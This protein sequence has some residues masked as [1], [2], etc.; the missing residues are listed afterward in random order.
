MTTARKN[1]K[2][3]KRKK[4]NFPLGEVSL[5][6]MIAAMCHSP[7]VRAAGITLLRD[8][9]FESNDLFH[10]GGLRCGIEDGAPAG[11]SN[12]DESG[13]AIVF[14]VIAELADQ[15]AKHDAIPAI[16][17]KTRI[18]DVFK[19]IGSNGLEQHT[20]DEVFG[21]D[22]SRGG[23]LLEYIASTSRD[24]FD[25]AVGVQTFQQFH[26]QRVTEMLQG[27][28]A[29]PN[30]TMRPDMLES[31]QPYFDELARGKAYGQGGD[32]MQ[33]LAGVTAAEFSAAEYTT[34][35]LVNSVMTQGQ[36]TVIGGPMK[37]MKTSIMLDLA[38][39]LAASQD[40]QPS[41][42]LGK[43]L[44]PKQVGVAI[45]SG[46]SGA[47]TIK[48][49]ARRICTSRGIELSDTQT[50]WSFTAPRLADP[51]ELRTITKTLRDGGYSVAAFDPLYLSLMSG[52]EGKSAA[53]L[54]DMGPLLT[55]LCAACLEAGATPILAHHTTKYRHDPR[56]RFEPLELQD[57]AFAGIA[58]FARQWILV[59]RREKYD[60]DG[61]HR[62]WLGI[63][64][65]AG[66]GRTLGLDITEGTVDE[67][68]QGRV[69]DVATMTVE[70]A[71]EA[72]KEEKQAAAANKQHHEEA[73]LK[74]KIL[75][76]LARPKNA[77]GDTETA[78]AHA[79]GKGRA[80]RIRTVLER[81]KLHHKIEKIEGLKKGRFTGTGW[82]KYTGQVLE[83]EDDDIQVE[84]AA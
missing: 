48:E 17:L 65:S 61:I 8:G 22:Q 21:D 42:F 16:A 64:G 31:M 26:Q 4:L 9:P 23:R 55:D 34:T 20:Y 27:V 44:V 6:A 81:L 84:D 36:P 40:E 43:F 75:E 69:W 39:S 49:T 24:D 33:A 35:W 47:P 3:K 57:L 51:M 67:H 83:D 62:L 72:V 25:D 14:E 37:S 74:K 18:H 2:K 56:D 54:F 5:D 73:A 76:Y 10:T 70:A 46:E 59:N 79:V 28:L 52:S 12:H 13:R 29:N 30:F 41:C 71:R 63:G 77:A 68:F 80:N 19:A 7:V 60:G 53:S 32:R 1:R 50:R 58:E 66:F 38:L 11:Y 78:I 15:Y 82:R 45:W